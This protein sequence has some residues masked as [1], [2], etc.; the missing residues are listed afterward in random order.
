M[1]NPRQNPLNY[2]ERLY[3][4]ETDDGMI[5]YSFDRLQSTVSSPTRLV[6]QGRIGTHVQNFVI[7][8]RR[9]GKELSSGY[10]GEDDTR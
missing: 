9:K 8:L 4:Y 3:E 7:D 1:A 5:L 6:L 10:D 2:G